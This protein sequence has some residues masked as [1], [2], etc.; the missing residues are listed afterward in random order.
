MNAGLSSLTKLKQAILPDSMRQSPLWD[1]TLQTLGLGIAD[2]FETYLDRKLAYVAGDVIETDAQRIFV[3]VPR[4]PV[5][6]F[7]SVQIQTTPTGTW[8]DISGQVTR[9]LKKEGMILFRTAPG[10]EAATIKTTY[11][12]GFWWDTDEEGAGTLPE[13]ATAL[14][15]ALFTAWSMQVQAQCNALDLFGAQSGKDVLGAASNLLT[16][17]DAFIPAVV[18][19]LK[20]FRRFAA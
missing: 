3:S 20:P 11:T 18:T 1:D 13:G 14:P 10:D 5:S 2:A 15:A 7:T 9:Y 16:N 8:E 17:A 12:G 4:Y 6:T 19:M